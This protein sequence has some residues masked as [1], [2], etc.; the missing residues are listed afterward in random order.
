ML[1]T[2]IETELA[3]EWKYKLFIIYKHYV[4]E[5]GITYKADN[6]TLKCNLF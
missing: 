6:Y 4:H 1:E 2:V 5:I 3:A